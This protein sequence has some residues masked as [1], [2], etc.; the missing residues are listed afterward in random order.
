M[1]LLCS[2]QMILLGLMFRKGVVG[3][4]RYL[5]K[6][7]LKWFPLFGFQWYMH[8][9][10]WIRS[11]P[12]DSSSESDGRRETVQGDLMNIH[13]QLTRL[14]D[15]KV[16]TWLILFPEGTR[17]SPVSK[18]RSQAFCRAKGLPV[19]NNVLYPRTKGFLACVEGFR[20]Y[21]PVVYDVT[22]AY[23]GR[24]PDAGNSKRRPTMYRFLSLRG[25][26]RVYVHITQHSSEDV[27]ADPDRWCKERWE[28]KDK[29]LTSLKETGHFPGKQVK[30]MSP[31]RS[32][33]GRIALKWAY[34]WPYP[35]VWN[36]A[37]AVALYVSFLAYKWAFL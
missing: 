29:L 8:D 9:F 2:I 27:A 20:K 1:C 3:H 7:S 31:S 37:L 23:E 18:E 5:L 30:L 10:V 33:L 11:R 21:A 32:A 25:P 36:T 28:A 35:F 13:K 14:C 26:S 12:H 17:A 15:R 4:T 16:P 19:F 34:Y 24:D 22:L 6:N